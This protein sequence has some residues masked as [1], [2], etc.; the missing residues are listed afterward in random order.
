MC[1]MLDHLRSLWASAISRSQQRQT[2]VSF[3]IISGQ[4]STIHRCPAF[5]LWVNAITIPMMGLSSSEIK[6]AAM[7]ELPLFAVIAP[8]TKHKLIQTIMTR[9]TMASMS[10]VNH[11]GPKMYSDCYPD[12][13]VSCC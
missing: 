9:N 12:L 2:I 5:G 3:L 6:N 4:N 1:R 7:N 10:E 11:T 13:Y 8:A